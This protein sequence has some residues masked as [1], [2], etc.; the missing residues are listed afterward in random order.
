RLQAGYVPADTAPALAPPFQAVAL[1]EWV[2]DG[3]RRIG[4][5]GLVAPPA[6]WVGAPPLGLPNPGA[7]VEGLRLGRRA[8]EGGEVRRRAGRRAV[9]E[10]DR[11][12]AVDRDRR[13]AR[14]PDLALVR[15]LPGGLRLVRADA[16]VP[17]VADEEVAAVRAEVRRRHR[18]APRRVQRRRGL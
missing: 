8:G 12:E 2:D 18:E 14:R 13:S 15:P 3:G 5:R 11:P 6:V 9:A 4:V 7:T 1:W 16:A 17:E 10:R